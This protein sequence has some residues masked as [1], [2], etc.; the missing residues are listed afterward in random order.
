M[1]PSQ[2]SP[3][4]WPD[5]LVQTRENPAL[6]ENK[7]HTDEVARAYGFAGGLVSGTVVFSHLTRPLVENLGE[8]WLV[9]GQGTVRFFQPAYNADRL[10]IRSISGATSE[11]VPEW[12]VGAYREDGR[13]LAELR[14]TLPERAPPL[15]AWADTLPHTRPEGAELP[16]VSWEAIELERPFWGYS[17]RPSLE[18]NVAW[19]DQVRDDLLLYRGEAGAPLHP[20]KALQAANEVF[21]RQFQLNPWI[22]VSSDMTFRRVLRVGEEIEVRAVPLKKFR[23]K[24][25]EIVSL[26]VLMLAGGEPALEVTH[27]AIFSI[28][29]PA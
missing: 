15:G 28:A 14:A 4:L 24:G 6:S 19:A 29:K 12:V 10:V 17:W 20:G 27:Q 23:K 21:K 5:Y 3:Q 1:R 25:H 13:C 7:I 11:G 26:Y 8:D 9:R 16:P 2:P 22:H 18:D